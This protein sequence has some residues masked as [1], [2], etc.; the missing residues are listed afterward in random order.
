MSYS[1]FRFLFVFLLLLCGLS[2]LE[3]QPLPRAGK[4][5][6]F[7]IFEGP[8][9]VFTDTDPRL[10][11][12][13][14]SEYDGC[15]TIYSPSGYYTEFQFRKDSITFIKLDHK[16]EILNETGKLNKGIIITTNEPINC[17]FHYYEKSAGDA[18]QLYPDEALDTSYLVPTWGIYNDP[19]EDNRT[20]IIV[21]AAENNTNVTIVPTVN[22]LPNY[23][24][25]VP[26]KVILNRGECFIAKA[27]ILSQP[28]ATSLSRTSVSSDKPVSV[29]SAATCA[30]VPL[31]V[32]SCNAIVDQVLSRKYMGTEFYVRPII[33][34]G[35]STYALIT[36]DT[37]QFSVAANGIVYLASQG[38][39][40]IEITDPTSIITTAPAQCHLFVAGSASGFAS[41]NLSDPSMVTLL[42]VTAWTD[43]LIWPYT[44]F[45]FNDYVTVIYDAASEGQILIDGNPISLIGIHVPIPNS[46]K[47]TL[48]A[49]VSRGLHRLTSP[50]PVYAVR[51]GFQADDA[52]TFLPGG[53]APISKIDTLRREF[54]LLR[55]DSCNTVTFTIAADSILLSA[56]S[57][58]NFRFELKYD[59]ARLA[60]W[61]M[62]QKALLA[63]STFTI[64]SSKKGSIVIVG[65]NTMP[66]TGRGDLVS[67]TFYINSAADSTS[68]LLFS[69]LSENR[70]CTDRKILAR[71]ES[72]QA[73]YQE[74]NRSPVSLTTQFQPGAGYDTVSVHLNSLPTG[75][76]VK[77]FTLTL[78]FNG[79]LL[80]IQKVLEGISLTE[81][82]QS[83]ITK[84]A[85]G[86]YSIHYH[87]DGGPLPLEGELTQLLLKSYVTKTDTT[88]IVIESEFV[89]SQPCDLALVSPPVQLPAKVESSCAD[90]ILREFM[91]VGSLKIEQVSP[92]PAHKTVHLR[93]FSPAVGEGEVK[94]YDMLGKLVW[95]QKVGLSQGKCQV[96]LRLPSFL[97]AGGYVLRAESLFGVTSTMIRI[98]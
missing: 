98:E 60:F 21:T 10:V 46:N 74:F 5:F 1:V 9:A 90:N 35:H 83:T 43:T 65:H 40:V 82:W 24:A 22:V 14:Y 8:D 76:E 85:E 39:S 56:D 45:D 51:S 15:G 94:L 36:S 62:L 20:E 72:A 57:V 69:G 32:E 25:G 11:L 52:Y 92:N 80:D 28:S 2:E 47:A 34:D 41:G 27:D 91:A 48:F 97:V 30:Y 55:S 63:N 81:G 70:F 96:E 4:S 66:L 23:P 54:T 29:I 3:A 61:R 64:D 58:Y 31:Q 16:L 68:V 71:D 79:D 12:S 44:P 42:P 73:F 17:V 93:L 33:N 49:D 50:T 88:T 7:S 89:N 84:I 77:D 37:K 18:T 95:S 67:L 75:A 26:I 78:S 53:T 19:G 87:T 86:K 13:I 59:T 6:T 38:Q